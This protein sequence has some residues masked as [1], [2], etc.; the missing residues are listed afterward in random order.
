MGIF[1]TVD[2][3]TGS[4]PSRESSPRIAEPSTKHWASDVKGNFFY[5]KSNGSMKLMTSKTHYYIMCLGNS[6]PEC[7]NI[8]IQATS[9]HPL[10]IYIHVTIL[11]FNSE[12]SWDVFSTQFHPTLFSSQCEHK[13]TRAQA[14]CPGGCWHL[15]PSA[16]QNLILA[17]PE[18]MP[19]ASCVCCGRPASPV[20]NA[21]PPGEEKHSSTHHIKSV[22]PQLPA[23]YRHSSLLHHTHGHMLYHHDS[24]PHIPWILAPLRIYPLPVLKAVIFSKLKWMKIN[25]QLPY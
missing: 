6:L 1:F 11:F 25:E 22:Q 3:G 5:N 23:I 13:E 4:Y 15:S 20:P 17:D 7:H 9:H 12:T 10:N 2:I 14:L 18:D 24:N 19:S 21:S 16:Y 8:S